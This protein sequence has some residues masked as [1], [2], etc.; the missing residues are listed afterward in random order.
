MALEVMAQAEGPIPLNVAFRVEPGELVALVGP[1]GSGKSTLL[2][3]IA[4]LWTPQA[5]RVTVG[6]AVWLDSA[7]GINLP[8]HQ[9]HLGMVFQS[10][11]LFPH[12]TAAA[13]VMAAMPAR[14]KAEN[15]AEAQRLLALVNLAS[16]GARYPADL[17]GGQ[18]QRV[19]V[20]R[21]LARSPQ[22][23]LLDEPFS[24]VDRATREG[25]YAEI[26]ALRG[27]LNMPVVLVT[28][29]IAEAQLLADRMV[30]IEAGHMLR[31]GTTAE[32]MFD[33]TVL[34]AMGIRDAGSALQ[35]CIAAQEEDGLTRLETNAGPI[36]LPRVD[37][38]VGTAVRV[39]IMAHE[40]ILSRSRPEG[41]SALNILPVTVH[42]VMQGDGPGVLVECRAGDAPLLV[43][44]TRRSAIGL[45]LAP[46][47]TCYAILKSM[48]VARDQ[49]GLASVT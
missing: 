24:A 18:Q 3:T 1:S 21:A 37:G 16:F 49:V 17:S 39:R 22:V 27:S 12:M 42:T 25:L 32:V 48:S 11:A 40:V 6:G 13:N 38:A 33:P 2:R 7:T 34:R 10:Y 46:G 44:I 41:L 23:L 8:P 26:A 30:V 9:R 28:H 19:A 45:G 14:P 5:A 43:R 4:G 31:D 29:D 15:R 35:A 20:A 47:V 36:W